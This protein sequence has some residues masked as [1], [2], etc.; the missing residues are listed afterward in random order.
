MPSISE[1]IRRRTDVRS[2][3]NMN[4]A[5]ASAPPNHRV[6]VRAA[7]RVWGLDL[8]RFLALIGMMVVHV[9]KL[10]PDGSETVLA[11]LVSGK[12]AALFALLAGVGVALTT[13]ADLAAGRVG[14][15]RASVFGRG[16]ALVVLGLTL[17]LMPTSV[18]VILVYYGVLF[19]L[20]IPLLRVPSRFLLLGAGLLALL[21]P[22]VSQF[23]RAGLPMSEVG[24]A[25][26]PQMQDPIVLLRGLFLTGTYPVPTWIVYALV[27]LVVGRAVI[28]A[29]TDGTILRL[30]RRLALAG[31]ALALGAAGVAAALAP[32]AL[33]ALTPEYDG[34]RTLVEL[35]YSSTGM[36]APTTGSPWWL[37]SAAPHSG[38][39]LDL[40]LTTGIALAVVGLCL[41][42]GTVVPAGVR[43]ALEPVR[44]AGSAPLTVYTLHVVATSL[45]T[46][47]ALSATGLTAYPWYIHSP[48]LWVLHVVGAV[49]IGAVL[50]VLHRRGP[51]ETLV[52]ASGRWA[53]A[54][55]RRPRRAPAPRTER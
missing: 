27:G 21:W 25:S 16:A 37:A 8:A 49:G 43:R 5:P 13:R 29:V 14:A 15:A 46:M 34:E 41:A 23:L 31:T 55:W 3:G 1:P 6:D 12:A 11:G 10:A 7:S 40:V 36:G 53:S 50:M 28:A 30:G 45:G 48:Q 42:L 52:S 54:P 18:V 4:H 51:L 22:V 35:I 24:S 39:T 2:V 33:D 20:L 19:W 38:T 9:W 44:R 47:V 17:A 32:V 26:W